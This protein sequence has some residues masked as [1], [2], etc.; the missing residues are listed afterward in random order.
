M[1]EE[2]DS[3][4]E[5]RPSRG[6]R[7]PSG[8]KRGRGRGGR[9]RG[10]G[11][12]TPGGTPGGRPAAPPPGAGRPLAASML[13]GQRPAYPGAGLAPGLAGLGAARPGMLPQVGAQPIM[14]MTPQVGG[15]GWAVTKGTS[16]PLCCLEHQGFWIGRHFASCCVRAC[17]C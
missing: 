12:G 15:G 8:G 10:R 7:P 14:M 4:D 17:E 6:S 2:E 1:V 9:G 13:Q 16:A 11:R 3:E 5:Y